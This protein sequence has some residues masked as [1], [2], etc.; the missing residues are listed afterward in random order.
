MTYHGVHGKVVVL[1]LQLHSMLVAHADLCVALK[2]QFLI[3][4]D[5]VKHLQRD[6]NRKSFIAYDS[7]P[8]LYEVYTPL[9]LGVCYY[10]DGMQN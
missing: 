2:K 7:A 8:F 3:V 1:S 10:F 4:T 6:D 9:S 5:P